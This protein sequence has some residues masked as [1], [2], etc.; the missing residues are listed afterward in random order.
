[1]LWNGNC[2]R[3]AAVLLTLLA[4]SD[5]D[6]PTGP[7]HHGPTGGGGHKGPLPVHLATEEAA[8]VRVDLRGPEHLL[9]GYAEL[10]LILTEVDGDTHV[11]GATVTVRPV[12]PMAMD[13]GGTM[14]HGAPSETPA[15]HDHEAGLYSNSVVLLM[16]GTW[17]LE[18]AFLAGEV[19]G[20]VTFELEVGQGGKLV[21]LEGSDGTSYFVALV[22]PG[23]PDVGKQELEIAVYRRESSNS[24]PPVTDLEVE[25]EPSMP[26]MEHGSPDNEQPL[27]LENGRYRGKVN[28]TMTG[29]WRVELDLQR[30][31]VSL[32][33]VEFDLSVN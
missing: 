28:F 2:G 6:S 9:T 21:A 18:V 7:H 14:V 13:D 11:H 19:A 10:Q 31:G 26:A 8:G 12:M 15:R 30:A 17:H 16:P 25:F 20:S 1:M 32:G 3:L 5:D 24:F 23:Q 4:C 33:V 29:D 27:H 22:G